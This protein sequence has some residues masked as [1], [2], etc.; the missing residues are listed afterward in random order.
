MGNEIGMI[1]PYQKQEILGVVK[2]FSKKES[3]TLIV[4]KDAHD[5]IVHK[6]WQDVGVVTGVPFTDA[7]AT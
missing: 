4:A 7:D 5:E 6:P 3:F 2:K 1:N